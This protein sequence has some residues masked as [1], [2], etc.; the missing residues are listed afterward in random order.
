MSINKISP[1]KQALLESEEIL[2][3]VEKNA[4]NMLLA[5]LRPELD[6]KIRE[7]IEADDNDD[8]Y[9]NSVPDDQSKDTDFGAQDSEADNAPIDDVP[10]V[11]DGGEGDA[12]NSDNPTIAIDEPKADGGEDDEIDLTGSSDED[13]I[14]VFKKLDGDAEIQ[15]VK[16]G[17]NLNI[18][19]ADGGE[20]VVQLNEEEK[21]SKENASV[22]KE[23]K[24]VHVKDSILE[25]DEEQPFDISN[26]KPS[27]YK[28]PKTVHV[29][30][31]IL[32]EQP[33]EEDKYSFI[34]ETEI[35]E[36]SDAKELYEIDMNDAPADDMSE[37]IE[38]VARTHADGRKME[39]KPEGFFKY[40]DSRLRPAEKGSVNES[41]DAKYKVL[42]SESEIKINNLSKKLDEAIKEN[43][44]LKEDLNQHRDTLAKTRQVIDSIALFNTNMSNVNKLF[45]SHSTTLDEKRNIAERFDGVETIKESNTLYKTISAELKNKTVINETVENVINKNVTGNTG[46]PLMESANANKKSLDAGL[47][48][49]QELINYKGK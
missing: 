7:S 29:K 39:R 24:T 4:K 3:A 42:L 11:V 41:I 21:A 32:E 36:C 47:S 48:R 13:V 15:V 16:D 2:A 14:K 30:D 28:D 25:N 37:P 6:K 10:A 49:I 40:A 1:L 26:K 18:T 23:P 43:V 17:E 33:L 45:C 35:A 31:S 44:I 34:D 19:T 46:E 9:D 12:E 5:Q 27:D 22:Y 8:A 20:Y 38:E